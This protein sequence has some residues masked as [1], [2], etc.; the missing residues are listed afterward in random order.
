M[1][2]A[3]DTAVGVVLQQQINNEWKPIVFFFEK[4]KPAETKYSTFDHKFLAVYIAM[5]IPNTLWKVVNFMFLL[6]TSH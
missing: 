3:S 1:M 5:N 4:L 2:D 6:I